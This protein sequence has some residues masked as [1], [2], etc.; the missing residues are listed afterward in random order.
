[1][2]TFPCG[3]NHGGALTFTFTYKDTNIANHNIASALKTTQPIL[4]HLSEAFEF[5]VLGI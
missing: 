3:A 2:Q 1:M 5:I 4:G